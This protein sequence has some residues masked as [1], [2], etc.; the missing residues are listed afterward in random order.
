MRHGCT[1]A[2]GCVSALVR[3]VRGPP[4]R[5]WRGAG[6]VSCRRGR[7]QAR[8]LRP[9][10]RGSARGAREPGTASWHR[11][12]GAIAA[13]HRC[14]RPRALRGRAPG[15]CRPVQRPGTNGSGGCDGPGQAERP[16]AGLATRLAQAE[17]RRAALTPARGRGT[18]PSRE[19]ATRVEA[20]DH[21]LKAQRVDG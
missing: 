10:P 17:H 16:T 4:G 20:I 18:R 2:L 8:R 6:A 7:G 11:A 14:S 21:G 9:G 5:P 19:D 15:A 3:G 12:A 13:A 1:A